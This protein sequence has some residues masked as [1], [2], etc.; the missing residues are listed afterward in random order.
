MKKILG[1][2]AAALVLGAGCAHNQ[3]K[4][5]QTE[6][7][8]APQASVESASQGQMGG[9]GALVGM[10]CE[11]I[12]TG[13]SGALGGTIQNEPSAS[14]TTGSESLQTES[15]PSE[16]SANVAQPDDSGSGDI[17]IGGLD[18]Q[19]DAIG[20][21]ASEDADL[22]GS[23]ASGL[24][25]GGAAAQDDAI[26]G[27]AAQDE[28]IG[29]SA[30]EDVAIGGSASQDTAIGGSA[31]QNVAPSGSA[32]EE[33]DTGDQASEDAAFERTDLGG[34]GGGGG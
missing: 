4:T 25:I 20:G 11:V 1:A 17:A 24:S 6:V 32:S 29:G 15:I 22:G 18:T 23:L 14:V 31:S 10:D 9:S 2:I 13:G 27:S 3:E 30:S 26:G 34:T 21:S 12:S 16:G 33:L 5:A 28:A 8:S 19:D 7:P